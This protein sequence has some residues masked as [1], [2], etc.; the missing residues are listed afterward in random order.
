MDRERQQQASLRDEE[1]FE[2]RRYVRQVQQELK[3]REMESALLKVGFTAL[4]S[5]R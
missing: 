2:N 5:D 1:N 4:M 3:E